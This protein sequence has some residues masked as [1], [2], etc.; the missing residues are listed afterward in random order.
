MLV[1]TVLSLGYSLRFI[2]TV[3][4]GPPKADAEAKKFKVP[5][6]M[7]AGMIMLAVLVIIVGIYPTFFLN[8]IGT[9]HFI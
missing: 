6:F 9:V 2:S 8:L 7:Q 1:A 3:F 4:F 5:K